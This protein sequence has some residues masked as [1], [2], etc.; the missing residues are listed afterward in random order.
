M[1]I[2]SHT[3]TL[4][5]GFHVISVLSVDPVEKEIKNILGI[6]ERLKIAF[7]CRLGYPT[8]RANQIPEGAP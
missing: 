5:I 8:L 3:E 6:P 7:V 1:I 4:G 2:L